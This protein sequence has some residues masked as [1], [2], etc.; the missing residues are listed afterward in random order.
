MK[1]LLEVKLLY[2][3]QSLYDNT[4]THT[5]IYIYI[6]HVNEDGEYPKNEYSMYGYLIQNIPAEQNFEVNV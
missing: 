3:H 4:H 6:Y 1:A 5:H 2:K